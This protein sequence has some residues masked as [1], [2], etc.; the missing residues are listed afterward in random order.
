M[1]FSVV[2]L[3]SFKEKLEGSQELCKMSLRSIFQV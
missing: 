3:K 2:T 1:G